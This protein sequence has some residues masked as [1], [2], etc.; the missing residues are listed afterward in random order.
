MKTSRIGRA[1]VAALAAITTLAGAAAWAGPEVAWDFESGL[2]PAYGGGNT[3][4]GLTWFFST[5]WGGPTIGNDGDAHGNYMRLDGPNSALSR[6]CLWM[7]D[8]WTA[9]FDQYWQRADVTWDFRINSIGTGNYIFQRVEVDR[10]GIPWS[11]DTWTYSAATDPVSDSNWHTAHL[12]FLGSSE[13]LLAGDG[14]SRGTWELYIDDEPFSSGNLGQPDPW[15]IDVD[16]EDFPNGVWLSGIGWGNWTATSFSMDI[17]NVSIR[18]YVEPPKPIPLPSTLAL[19][20]AACLGLAS[21]Q[22][23]RNG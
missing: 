19:I 10:P 22:R 1:A 23:R 15:G 18:D 7:P 2:P 8:D 16:A 13:A 11:A 4:L 17:D 3:G 14:K 9:P 6:T 5:S 21:R 20:T 12:V